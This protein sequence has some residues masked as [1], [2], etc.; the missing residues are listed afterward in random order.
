MGVLY[1]LCLMHFGSSAC[2][3]TRGSN[4]RMVA[5]SMRFREHVDEIMYRATIL[6]AIRLKD[7]NPS[8]N[9]ILP[10]CV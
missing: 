1:V 10:V 8:E 5:P 2:H 6:K 4:D 9:D 3:R 7:T